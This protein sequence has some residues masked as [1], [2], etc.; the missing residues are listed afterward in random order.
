MGKTKMIRNHG[1]AKANLRFL[2]G[3]A[4]LRSKVKTCNPLMPK[5][6]IRREAEM[7]KR[8]DYNSKRHISLRCKLASKKKWR[9]GRF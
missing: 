2:L 6:C 3:K 4:P 9:R 1:L 8:R 5:R 7:R